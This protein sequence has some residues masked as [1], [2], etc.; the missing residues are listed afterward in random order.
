M[1]TGAIGPFHPLQTFPTLYAHRDDKQ[2]ADF[3]PTAE[4]ADSEP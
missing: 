2:G 1:C 4:F 3:P